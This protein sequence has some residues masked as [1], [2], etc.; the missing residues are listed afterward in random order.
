[1]KPE[2]FLIYKNNTA[3]LTHFPTMPFT[4]YAET[5]MEVCGWVPILAEPTITLPPLPFSP[6][7]FRN[8]KR[9]PL[10]AVMSAKFVKTRMAISGLVPK[11][12]A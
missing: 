6:N 9:T 2:V 4:P 11:T 12:Q 1:M 10:V 7:I 5:A 3:I 8:N